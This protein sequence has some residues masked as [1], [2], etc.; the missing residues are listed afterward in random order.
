MRESVDQGAKPE[1]KTWDFVTSFEP[2][3]RAWWKY[4]KFQQQLRKHICPKGERQAYLEHYEAVR[5]YVP[6]ERLLD[7]DV[8]EGW[9]PLCE[10]LEK[11]V[12]EQGF[13]LINDKD[14]WKVARTQRWYKSYYAM[15]SAVLPPLGVVLGGAIGWWAAKI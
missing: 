5:K 14:G 8:K 15:V 1:W 11:E 10:F 12:P 7:F 4:Q 2:S 13:P 9:E 6:K 3:Q